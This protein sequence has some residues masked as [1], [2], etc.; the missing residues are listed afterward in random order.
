MLNALI[1]ALKKEMIFETGTAVCRSIENMSKD[2]FR[3]SLD[4]RI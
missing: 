2:I 3:D 1:S 4:N